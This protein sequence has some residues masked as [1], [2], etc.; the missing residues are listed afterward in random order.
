MAAAPPA[1]APAAPPAR[2]RALVGSPPD[3]DL[4]YA[5]AAEFP[6]KPSLEP[7]QMPLIVAAISARLEAAARGTFAMVPQASSGGDAGAVEAVP[8]SRY[9]VVWWLPADRAAELVPSCGPAHVRRGCAIYRDWY[10]PL[11]DR[12]SLKGLH[13]IL[14]ERLG[15]AGPATGHFCVVDP[16]VTPTLHNRPDMD[17]GTLWTV[18]WWHGVKG[19]TGVPE[20]DAELVAVAATM[21][22]CVVPRVHACEAC[23]RRVRAAEE[24]VGAASAAPAAAP[25]VLPLLVCGGC[26]ATRYCGREC[27]AM[28]WK[29]M[30]HKEQCARV[31]AQADRAAAAAAATA[32]L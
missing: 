32:E 6:P 17:A 8:S 22:A 21:A 2:P 10:V 3:A 30:G 7:A 20:W 26:R 25:V 18:A 13:E 19:G 31:R 12:A 11:R 14:K 24:G 27:A 1:S 29:A 15:G 28:G 5:I 9:N 16:R 23:R 4:Y